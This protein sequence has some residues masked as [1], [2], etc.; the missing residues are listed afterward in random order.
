MFCSNPLRPAESPPNRSVYHSN[1]GIEML[2]ANNR[3][4]DFWKAGKMPLRPLVTVAVWHLAASRWE[5]H[6]CPPILSLA[7][8]S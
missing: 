7:C 5:W 3:T 4:K 6:F 2:T 1:D 8:C